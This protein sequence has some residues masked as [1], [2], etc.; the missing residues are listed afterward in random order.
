MV[1]SGG[2]GDIG[3]IDGADGDTGGDVDGDDGG[4]CGDGVGVGFLLSNIHLFSFLLNAPILISPL[5]SAGISFHCFTDLI[6]KLL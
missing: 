5:I 3:D 2:S 4:P 1:G 6:L